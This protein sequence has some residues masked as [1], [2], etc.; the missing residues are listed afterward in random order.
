[1][2]TKTQFVWVEKCANTDSIIC[3]HAYRTRK[4]VIAHWK[5]M[6]SFADEELNDLVRVTG[7]DF[8]E[9]FARDMKTVLAHAWRTDLQK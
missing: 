2:A 3:A 5:R 8:M 1:M 4:G 7:K 6:Y 9:I